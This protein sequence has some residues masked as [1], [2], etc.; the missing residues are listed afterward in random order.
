M[1]SSQLLFLFKKSSLITRGVKWDLFLFDLLL[2]LI[3][4]LGTLCLLIGLFATIPTSMMTTVF[5]YRKLAK[6][7]IE[8]SGQD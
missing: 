5:V 3:N 8:V 6:P 4:F 7:D 2:T 1:F